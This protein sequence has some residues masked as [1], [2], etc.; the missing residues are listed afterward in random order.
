MQYTYITGTSRGIGKALAE[1]LLERDDQKVIGISRHKT[2]KHKRY[3]HIELDLSKITSIKR[4]RFEKLKKP[5]RIVLVNNAGTID[6]AKPVG[7]IKSPEL[8]H[9]LNVNLVAPVVLVNKFIK[10]FKEYDCPKII[11]N[12][13]SGAGKHAVDGWAAYCISKA[14]IDMLT[15]VV[16][17]ELELAGNPHGFYAFSIAPGIIDTEMQAKVRSLDEEDFSRAQEFKDY[18]AKGQLIDPRSVAE[19]LVA[20]MDNP[21]KQEESVFRFSY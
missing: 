17:R 9:A 20:V 10:F 19:K 12:I 13:S 2:I 21:E 11:I 1:K 16:A 7:E 6:P 5:S 14:G 3:L 18:K 4:F 15:R 8:V